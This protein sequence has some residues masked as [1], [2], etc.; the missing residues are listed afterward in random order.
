MKEPNYFI[1][2]RSFKVFGFDIYYYA[3]M[4]VCGII[5]AV[6]VASLLMKRRNIPSDWIFDLILCVLPLGIIGARTFSVI[7]DPSSSITEWFSKFREGG[8]SIIGGVIG[9]ALGVV[10]FCLIH[11][12]NFFRIADCVVPGLALAQAIG[13][14]GNFFNQ[15]VYGAQVTDPAM[16][17]FPFAV[18]I[19]SSG[20]WHYAFFFYESLVNLAVFALLF[21]FMWKFMKKPS[22]LAMCGYFFCY[23]VTR[24]IMEPLRDA[25]FILGYNVPISFVFSVIMCVGGALLALGLLY[26]NRRKYG[27]C[28][29]AAEGEPLAILPRYYTKEQLQKMEEAR[30]A[31]E[32]AAKAAAAKSQEDETQKKSAVLCPACGARF[33]AESDVAECPFC[34]SPVNAAGNESRGANTEVAN[35]CKG[36]SEDAPTA[37]KGGANA[38]TPDTNGA[39][40]TGEEE[41]KK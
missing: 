24:S 1:P 40:A 37:G 31:K 32:K 22:G 11:K 29:G 5:L 2:P 6:I 28:F 15:E 23:G 20:T 8:L 33:I 18:Y 26:Y 34:H 3:V 19:E 17:W 25:Q 14:W 39:V 38:S 21:T 41:E 7:T 36:G 30:L 13:R 27:R 10:L 4:I 16:Q 35:E 9:G 12:V